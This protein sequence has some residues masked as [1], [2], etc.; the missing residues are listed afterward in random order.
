MQTSTPTQK[1]TQIPYPTQTKPLLLATKSCPACRVTTQWLDKQGI[2]YEKV[3]AD[4]NTAVVEKY[5]VR[6]VPVLVM[7]APD[8]QEKTLMGFYEIRDYYS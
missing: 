4:E 8:G 3:Y 5:H 2:S 1:G 6:S 7:L